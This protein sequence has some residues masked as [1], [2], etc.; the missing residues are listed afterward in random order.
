MSKQPKKSETVGEMYSRLFRESG[1]LEKM[2]EPKNFAALL[3]SSKDVELM[4]FD[5]PKPPRS[6]KRQKESEH[7]KWVKAGIWAAKYPELHDEIVGTLIK[8]AFE[9]GNAEEVL[10]AISKGVKTTKS[11]PDLSIFSRHVISAFLTA[12]HIMESENRLPTK[13]DVRN[14]VGAIFKERGWGGLWKE[15]Q[16]W[17]EVF[18]AAGLGDLPL[19]KCEERITKHGEHSAAKRIRISRH[20]HGQD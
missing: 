18:N 16:R 8:K 1:L 7:H 3:K 17:T 5:Q 2:R 15:D 6:T 20:R 4:K 12:T 19:R 13:L 11:K 14:A 9:N 10:D